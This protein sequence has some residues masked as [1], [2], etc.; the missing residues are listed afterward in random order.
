MKTHFENKRHIYQN[1]EAYNRDHFPTKDHLNVRI[2]DPVC[3]VHHM[4]CQNYLP[5]VITEL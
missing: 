4:Q 1:H 5:E 2:G 3:K